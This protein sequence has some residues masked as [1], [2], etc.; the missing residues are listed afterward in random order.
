[1][2]PWPFTLWLD[3]PRG[4]GRVLACIDRNDDADLVWV[5]VYED[6]SMWCHM[7]SE[8]R[9]AKNVTYGVRDGKDN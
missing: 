6:G 9:V 5:C 8:V 4:Q 3:T 7:N 2:T 1:M